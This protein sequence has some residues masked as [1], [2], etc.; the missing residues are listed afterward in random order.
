MLPDLPSPELGTDPGPYVILFLVG[1]LVGILGHLLRSRTVLATGILMVFLA[2]F[3]LPLVA[4]LG[5]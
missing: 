5:R 2:T 4:T 1:L 3:V